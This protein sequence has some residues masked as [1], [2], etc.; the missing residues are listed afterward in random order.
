MES[1]ELVHAIR[2]ASYP[3]GILAGAVVWW[4]ELGPAPE[5]AIW[6]AVVVFLVGAALGRCVRTTLLVADWLR[7][8]NE[9]WYRRARDWRSVGTG[10]LTAD[11]TGPGEGPATR[12]S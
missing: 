6:V 8:R 2:A 10:S 1:K 7:T 3:V 5:T 12:R 9:G 11:V 4:A